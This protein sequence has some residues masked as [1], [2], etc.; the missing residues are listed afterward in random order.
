MHGEKA[1]QIMDAKRQGVCC[2]VT[3]A[4]AKEGRHPSGDE[5]T[6]EEVRWRVGAVAIRGVEVAHN[7]RALV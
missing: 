2:C 3:S 5:C 6:G 1:M 7:V 4:G